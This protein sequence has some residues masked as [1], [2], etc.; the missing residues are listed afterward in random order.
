MGTGRHQLH[1][2]E[3]AAAAE[4]EEE[5]KVVSDPLAVLE[6]GSAIKQD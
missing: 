1:E 4:E 5:V 3:V 6:I 2:E